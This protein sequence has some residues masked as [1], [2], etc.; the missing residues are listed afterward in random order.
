MTAER[1]YILGRE[2]RNGAKQPLGS[3]QGV[4]GKGS[5]NVRGDDARLMSGGDGVYVADG[6]KV[7]RKKECDDERGVMDGLLLPNQSGWREER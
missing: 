3:R 1:T 6:S 7:M 2:E 4:K 5:K